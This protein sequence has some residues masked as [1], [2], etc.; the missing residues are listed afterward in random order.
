MKL[1]KVGNCF[2]KNTFATYHQNLTRKKWGGVG[3]GGESAAQRRFLK[4][5]GRRFLKNG[6]APIFENCGAPIFDN[7]RAPIFESW[8]DGAWFFENGSG[9]N[10]RSCTV[11]VPFVKLSK[12]GNF[13]C[14]NTFK[15]Y[16]QHLTRKKWVGWGGVGKVPRSADF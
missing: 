14:K 3:R 15:T 8:R 1:S 9:E 2:C 12:F 13:F 4:I 5:A 6:R 16:H 7:G 11:G 10:V